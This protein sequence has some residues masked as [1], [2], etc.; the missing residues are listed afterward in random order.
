[1]K[2][3]LSVIICIAGIS[4]QYG[5]SYAKDSVSGGSY[6]IIANPAIDSLVQNVTK[7]KCLN[8]IENSKPQADPINI[9]P[10]SQSQKVLGYKIQV[11]Y[12]KDRNNAS[13]VRA[14]FAKNFPQLVPEMVYTQPDYRV[15]AG[16]YFTKRSAAMDL[17]AVKRKYPGAFLVQWRVW[18]RKAK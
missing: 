18:C 12:T 11:M 9:D 14:E 15:I 5:Q 13:R 8:P 10:C 2:F 16:D 1:M 17:N 7:A 6:T 4:L 3:I